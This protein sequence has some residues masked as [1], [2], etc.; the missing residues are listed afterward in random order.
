ML[1]E[2][3]IHHI[4]YESIATGSITQRHIIPVRIPPDTMRA[5]DVSEC[6]DEMRTELLNLLHEYRKYHTTYINSMLTF[7]KWVD[8]TYNKEPPPIKWRS[9]KVNR[10]K[11]LE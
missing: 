3:T 9:F 6:P 4:E 5:M 8:H 1:T 11:E 7:E 10:L 2:G